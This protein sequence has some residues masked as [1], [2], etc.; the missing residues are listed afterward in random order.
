MISRQLF[1]GASEQ[2]MDRSVLR[3]RR[4]L[5]CLLKCQLCNAPERFLFNLGIEALLGGSQSVSQS[6]R[7]YGKQALTH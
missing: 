2:W 5:L 7:Q 4:R 3:R 1:D 6:L